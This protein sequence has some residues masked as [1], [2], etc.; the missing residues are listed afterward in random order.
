MRN[1]GSMDAARDWENELLIEKKEKRT[2]HESEGYGSGAC[3]G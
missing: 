3:K 1:E 2:E